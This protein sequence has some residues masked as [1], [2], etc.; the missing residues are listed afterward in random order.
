MEKVFSGTAPQ[1]VERI[2]DG[3][4]RVRWDVQEENGSFSYREESF[5]YRPSQSEIKTLVIG[6]YDRLCD[7]R[8][9]SGHRWY[10]HVVWLSME[11]QFN[12][13]A[14]FDFAFQTVTLGG[15]YQPVTFKLGVDGEPH[16]QTFP[17][18]D[19]LHLFVG[20]CLMHINETLVAH[21]RLKDA[22]DWSVYEQV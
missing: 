8:I 22:I 15:E 12:Y 5:P 20:S 1:M 14:A 19:E 2:H 17:S 3:D 9:V 10:N 7:E 4:Y 13:K 21:W 11:N 18:I 16:Y 6:Y